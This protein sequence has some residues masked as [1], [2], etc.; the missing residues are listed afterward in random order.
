MMLILDNIGN[1]L[2]IFGLTWLVVSY[3]EVRKRRKLIATIEDTYKSIA[4]ASFSNGFDLSN[5][6]R[7]YPDSFWYDDKPVTEHT[8]GSAFEAFW[9]RLEKEPKSK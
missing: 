7:Y 6:Q 8:V 1:A 4:K 3:I 5:K 9:N 2:I